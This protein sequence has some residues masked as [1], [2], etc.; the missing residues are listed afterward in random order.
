MER[1]AVPG[2]K[3][4]A[5]DT[6]GFC[7][8]HA[9]DIFDSVMGHVEE[10]Y[11]IASAIY[12]GRTAF[13]ERRLLQHVAAAGRDHLL[14]VHWAAQWPEIREFEEALIDAIK[15][16]PKFRKLQNASPFSEGSFSSPWNALYISFS[17]K[18]GASQQPGSRVVDKL[19]WRHRLWPDPVIPN[20]PVLLRYDGKKADAE[21]ELAR[22]DRATDPDRRRRGRRPGT[23]L[24]AT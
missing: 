2:C 8:E 3:V 11:E 6:H 4:D 19:H 13:P 20:A 22:F 1:C 23:P 17:L 14:V 21:G 5:E 18:A 16:Q 9:D 15:S 7:T 12:F 10:V 24:H